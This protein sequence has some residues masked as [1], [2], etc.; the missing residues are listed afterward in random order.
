MYTFIIYIVKFLLLIINGRIQV[1]GKEH[2]PEGNYILVAPHHSYI[3]PV[4]IAIAGFPDYY[5]FMVKEELTDN[6]F[7]AFLIDKL[8]FLPVN[9]ENPG[10][11][12]I[13]EP[14][15]LLKAGEKSFMLFPT[16]SRHSTD[17]KNGAVTIAKMSG[18]PIVPVVYHGP[19]NMKSLFKRQNM[20]VRYGEPIK[21]DRSKPKDEM[22]E[23]NQ[24]I[25]QAFEDLENKIKDK[26]NKVD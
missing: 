21:V 25:E 26:K 2:L 23:Y 20:V 4:P 12:V 14:V 19:L 24:K 6:K 11:S 9:R 16:G 18:K 8:E 10:P 3:D 1:Q 15:K 17:M 5:I 22:I 7:L 13:K